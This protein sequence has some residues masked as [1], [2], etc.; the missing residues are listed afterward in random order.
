MTYLE[1]GRVLKKVTLAPD[2]FALHLDTTKIG[3]NSLPGQFI[4]LRFPT[5]YD[6]YLRRPF[7]VADTDGSVVRIVFRIRGRGTSLLSQVKEGEF[8]SLLGPL[9]KPAPEVSDKEIVLVGGGIGIAPLLFLAKSLVKRNKVL[10]FFGAKTGS[11]VIM[12]DDFLR[13]GIENIFLATENG[14]IGEKGKITD[15]LIKNRLNEK[16]IV[17]AS[18]PKGMYTELK[19]SIPNKIYAFL[20]ERMGCGTGLCLSC[21]I[22]KKGGGYF[23][24]CRD[25][26]IL[27][28]DTIDL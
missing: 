26:P 2:I 20:E 27:D 13:L 14:E 23:H 3:K 18:G 5:T 7:A 24:L 11:E 1:S 22:R 9:G 8:L 4:S 12:R 10:L 25:G 21:A 19:K 6:P 17:F 28:L 15:L 16:A